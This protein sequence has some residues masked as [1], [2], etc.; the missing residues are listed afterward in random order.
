MGVTAATGSTDASTQT[1]AVLTAEMEVQVDEELS[2]PVATSPVPLINGVAPLTTP[3]R[4]VNPGAFDDITP[5]PNAFRAGAQ[6]G[7]A[8]VQTRDS[9]LQ[10]RSPFLRPRDEDARTVTETPTDGEWDDAR[11]SLTTPSGLTDFHSMG[12]TI[13]GFQSDDDEQS[14]RAG[15]VGTYNHRWSLQPQPQAR[16]FDTKSIDAARPSTPTLKPAM[17]EMST[18][19][20]APAPHTPG[21]AAMGFTRI[22]TPSQFK[23]I[24]SATS[25][26]SEVAMG[27]R[28][29]TAPRE[30]SDIFARAR[31]DRRSIDSDVSSMRSVSSPKPRPSISSVG[32]IVQVDRTRPPTMMLPPPPPM[33]PPS[34]P[35]QSMRRTASTIVPPPRPTSPPPPELLQRATTPTFGPGSSLLVPQ[36][37]IG[38]QQSSGMSPVG[39]LRQ[40]PSTSSFRSAS[41]ARPAAVIAGA[42]MASGSSRRMSVSSD[43]SSEQQHSRSAI[44]DQAR[45]QDNGTTDPTIIHSI[46]QTMIGEF[47][48]KYTR[49]VVG[50][51][52]GEKRHK[53]FF[54]IHPY[55]K[56]LYW[57][58]ADPGSNGVSES[59]AKSA[60]IDSVKSVL[61]PNPVPP[62]IY[63]YSIIVS[64]PQR[65]MKFTAPTKERHDIWFSALNYLLARP[66]TVA[67]SPESSNR[68][69]FGSVAPSGPS[70][71]AD[72]IRQQIMSSP[73]SVRTTGSNTYHDGWNTTPKAFRSQSQMSS[74]GSVGKRTGTPA[75][76][77]MRWNPPEAQS[78][79][80]STRAYQQQSADDSMDF[81]NT[82]YDEHDDGFV[83]TEPEHGF[84]GLENVRACCDGAH[85][86]AEKIYPCN[87]STTRGSSTKLSSSGDKIVYTNGRSVVIR[88]LNT[89]AFGITYSQHVQPATVARISPSGYYCASA[90]SGGNVKIWDIAGTDQVLKNEKKAI[91][92]KM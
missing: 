74:A 81:E 35:S 66:S 41:N 49:K 36:R 73:R 34:M 28:P 50:K 64:T 92:G 23:Y 42:S 25:T 32:P 58:D 55:T 88:D 48:Y 17:R 51:G 29:A 15:R 2:T 71:P 26:P 61:D 85:D 3:P 18:Q 4:N 12:S 20:D 89:P 37:T 65:E 76:E 59:S 9:F 72:E 56:T 43:R 68:S 7:L 19:T 44:A 31:D 75:A 30:G 1:R 45:L 69:R 40:P 14:I 57:S 83:P 90:D 52:H 38:R 11:E 5:T 60:Y 62:G 27:K 67:L 46:T 13:N 53:R 63:Q 47:L 87:P 80:K 86:I 6:L 82:E 39:G 10:A 21:G 33:P 24:P 78:P 79:T 22:G 84:E 8:P 16:E 91:S 77:Y 54:W 70:G